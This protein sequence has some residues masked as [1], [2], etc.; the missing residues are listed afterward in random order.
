MGKLELQKSL[1][2]RRISQ[3][4]A[5]VSSV[6]VEALG[7]LAA[8]FSLQEGFFVNYVVTFASP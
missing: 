6:Q 3:R 1:P 8:Q 2:K 5:L 7:Q 4:V